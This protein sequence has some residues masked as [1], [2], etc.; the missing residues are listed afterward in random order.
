M[1]ITLSSFVDIN[2]VEDE[3]VKWSH[4]ETSGI[5]TFFLTDHTV[6]KYESKTKKFYLI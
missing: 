1:K 6:W 3:L 5:Y 4:D 2:I